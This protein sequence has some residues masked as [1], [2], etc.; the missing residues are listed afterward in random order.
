MRLFFIILFVGAVAISVIVSFALHIKFFAFVTSILFLFKGFKVTFVFEWMLRFLFVRVPQRIVTSAMKLYI[1]DRQRSQ[2]II[3]WLNARQRYWR[4]HHKVRIITLGAIALV[5]MGISA[6]WVGIWLLVIYEFEVLIGMIWQK[7]SKTLSETALVSMFDKTVN[8]L[9]A[10]KFGR[11]I[12]GF[13]QW[14]ETSVRQRI[15]RL[16]EH[17]KKTI[18]ALCR[19]FVVMNAKFA[20]P[21]PP[22][23]CTN[24]TSLQNLKAAPSMRAQ[25][26]PTPKRF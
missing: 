3:D 19:E 20:F 11:V 18:I 7:V 25:H 9:H 12:T 16:G 13:D 2:K 5:V 15:E 14:V 1:I 23:I 24:V 21:H 10:T 8:Y 22:L 6:W 26:I 17:H 4:T